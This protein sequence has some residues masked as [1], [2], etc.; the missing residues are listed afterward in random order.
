M[1]RRTFL[2]RLLL[3]S[4]ICVI[5]IFSCKSR[6]ADQEQNLPN[7]PF[8]GE[9]QEGI[10]QVLSDYPGHELG[11]SAAVSVPGYKI[12]T[13]VSGKS[14]QNASVTTDMLFDI[15]SI[16]KNF[17]AALVLKLAEDGLLS[18]EDPISMYLP[19]LKNVNG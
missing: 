2:K 18:L 3:M 14:H 13:G 19:T 12:W 15:G 1:V 7:L 8:T 6:I 11:I 5:G 16:E 9:L 10:D 4:L 17:E